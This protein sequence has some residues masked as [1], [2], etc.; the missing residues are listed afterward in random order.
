MF[1]LQAGIGLGIVLYL[2]AKFL[3]PAMFIVLT[4]VFTFRNI[5]RKREK[6]KVAL[7]QRDYITSFLMALFLTALIILATVVV[8][9]LFL[10]FFVDLSIS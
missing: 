4:G 7:T 2:I 3:F 5:R 10:F 6:I 8:I 9:L 1:Q